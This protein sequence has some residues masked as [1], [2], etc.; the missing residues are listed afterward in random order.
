MKINLGSQLETV[1]TFGKYNLNFLMS[2]IN[3]IFSVSFLKSKLTAEDTLKIVSTVS[4]F[5][6]TVYGWSSTVMQQG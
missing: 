1:V 5:K 4:Y 6:N 3:I 2:A